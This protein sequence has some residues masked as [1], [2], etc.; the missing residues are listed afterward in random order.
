MKILPLNRSC[1]FVM[2]GIIIALGIVT[3]CSASDVP[4]FV[5]LKDLNRGGISQKIANRIGFIKTLM[6]GGL[7]GSSFCTATLIGPDVA[8][9]A[10]HC[11]K[12]GFSS[13]PVYYGFLRF[14]DGSA[15]EI[16]DAK[17]SGG[18][19]F[20][21]GPST[22]QAAIGM[23][24]HRDIAV[25][26]LADRPGDRLGW[27]DIMRKEEEYSEPDLE[28]RLIG[29]KVDLQF[30]WQSFGR[31][32]KISQSSCSISLVDYYLS[33]GQR[34]PLHPGKK[35]V[36]TNCSSTFGL[37]GGP[38]LA[39]DR[40]TK[41]YRIAGVISNGVENRHTNVVPTYQYDESLH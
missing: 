34:L 7:T 30:W 9:T 35:L 19:S 29:Y 2:C 41:S 23:H 32:L 16:V 33:G 17:L 3:P 38:M 36:L 26:R 4:N 39:Y 21:P 15:S 28:V 1:Y 10:G 6:L 13:N 5:P 22:P 14:P 31:R 24:V 37:S 27:I 12:N 18:Q 8:I 25:I 11:I 40:R 20:K